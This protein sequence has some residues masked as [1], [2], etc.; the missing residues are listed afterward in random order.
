MARLNSV[1]I[2]FFLFSALGIILAAQEQETF[3]RTVSDAWS[4]NKAERSA[5]RTPVPRCKALEPEVWP[6]GLYGEAKVLTPRSYHEDYS[7]APYIVSWHHAIIQGLRNFR[8]GYHCLWI[9]RRE[10]DSDQ[11]YRATISQSRR[12]EVQGR[13]PVAED[14]TLAVKRRPKNVQQRTAANAGVHLEMVPRL[15][16]QLEP[17]IRAVERLRIR[18]QP[19]DHDTERLGIRSQPYDPTLRAWCYRPLLGWLG[20]KLP[21]SPLGVLVLPLFTLGVKWRF[22][23]TFRH[24]LRYLSVLVLLLSCLDIRVVV[25]PTVVTCLSLWGLRRLGL[26][27]SGSIVILAGWTVMGSLDNLRE[28]PAWLSD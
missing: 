3:S 17:Y 18:P 8:L 15:A 4:A 11:A 6:E 2:M 10:E 20:Q 1:L 22:N 12:A 5:S 19:D 26:G 27:F 13:R 25:M 28:F 16:L 7:A 9:A 21:T 14:R 23:L 24:T